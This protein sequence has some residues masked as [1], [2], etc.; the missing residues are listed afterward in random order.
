VVALLGAV[1]WDLTDDHFWSR[2]ELFGNLIV[3]SIVVAVTAAVLDALFTSSV[4]LGSCGAVC[5]SAPD[6]EPSLCP[7]VPAAPMVVLWLSACEAVWAISSA[8]SLPLPRLG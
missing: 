2:H 8:G 7:T 4:R 6:G 3:G 1:A 5:S